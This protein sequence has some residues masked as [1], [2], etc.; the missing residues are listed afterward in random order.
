MLEGVFYSYPQRM[1]RISH[2][3]HDIGDKAL[4]SL[5]APS[6]ANERVRFKMCPFNVCV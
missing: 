4:L 3:Q 1:R 6:T 5:T 2:N